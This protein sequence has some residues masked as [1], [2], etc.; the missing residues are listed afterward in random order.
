MKNIII[1]LLSLMI[2][3]CG[4]MATLI[5]PKVVEKIVY[6]ERIVEVPAKFSLKD[7]FTGKRL[8]VK[9]GIGVLVGVFGWSAY[10]QGFDTG[11]DVAR[12]EATSSTRLLKDRLNEEMTVNVH[13]RGIIRHLNAVA[14]A[15][16]Q[17]NA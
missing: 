2:A 11:R 5:Q 6:K 9:L 8:I 15:A 1:V 16:N 13:L 7:E 17:P 10:D 14:I 4:K 3:G 12:N